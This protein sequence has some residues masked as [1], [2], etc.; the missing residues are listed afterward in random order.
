MNVTVNGSLR[1]LPER[2]TLD[3]VVEQDAPSRRGVAVA[4]NGEVVP[5]ASWD[6]T[7]L[8]ESDRVEIL[9]AIG[10]G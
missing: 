1:E 6:R 7:E 10:G 2:S 5:K 4:L 8:R 3:V 9:S